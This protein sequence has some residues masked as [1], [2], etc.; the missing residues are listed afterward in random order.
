MGNVIGNYDLTLYYFLKQKLPICYI[1]SS[2]DETY[3]RCPFCGDSKKDSRKARFYISNKAPFKFYCFNCETTGIITDEV[4]DLLLNGG[5]YDS[6]LSEYI[7]IARY[8]AMQKSNKV[9][10]KMFRHPYFDMTQSVN[11]NFRKSAGEKLD[12]LNDR[13][14]ISLDY[15]DIPKFKIVLSIKSF[16]KNNGLDLDKRIGD[17]DKVRYVVDSLDKNYIGF[18]SSDR[19]IIICRN[20]DN[21]SEIRFNNFKIFNDDNLI[22]SKVYN[23]GTTIDKYQDKHNVVIAEGPIDIIGS[24]FNVYDEPD[25]NNHIFLANGGKSYIN[26][27]NMLANLSLLNNEYT[28]MSDNDIDIDF[29]KRI[30][31]ATPAL[32]GS[33]MSIYYNNIGKDFGVSKDKIELSGVFQL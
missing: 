27:A 9:K 6:Q 29:Y 23:I 32:N 2:Q 16:F 31:S 12:Y 30:K 21:N 18:L 26:S 4:L 8:E 19:N 24:Y 10:R 1:T 22:S 28:I 3:V 7:R 17:S 33:P 14:G 5:F 25:R 15:T 20:L 13:L 11:Y